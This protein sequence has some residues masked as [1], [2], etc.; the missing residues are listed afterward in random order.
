MRPSTPSH[1]RA[2]RCVP[3]GAD[4]PKQAGDPPVGALGDFRG[5]PELMYS[6]ALTHQQTED[7]WTYFT[8]ANDTRMV[9][10]PTTLSC[11]GYNNKCSTYTAYG[12][13][14]GPLVHD[15]FCHV[16]GERKRRGGG[17][18]RPPTNVSLLVHNLKGPTAFA[19]AG[20]SRTEG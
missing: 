5:I 16:Q 12:M 7:L 11:A 9:T 19:C 15:V 17:T 14:Y 4:P 13:A 8:Y 1:P 10:R 20:A 18:Y 6:G 2:P 3:T